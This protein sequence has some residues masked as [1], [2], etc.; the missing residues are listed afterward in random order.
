MSPE[1]IDASIELV[2]RIVGYPLAFVV[3]PFAIATFAGAPGH[4]WAGKTYA[5]AMTFLYLTG[6]A[7]TLTRHPWA[8]WEFARNVTFNLLG[9]SFLLHGWRAMWLRRRPRPFPAWMDQVLVASLVSL[10]GALVWLA[11]ARANTP[12]RVFALVGTALVMLEAMEWRAGL[13]GRVL[14]RRHVRYMLASYFYVLTVVSLV[15]LRD[16][17]SSDAR[18]L[19][20]SAIA[21]AVI[22]VAGG[23]RREPPPR[24]RRWA[25]RAV[26][27]V[28]VAFGAYAGWEVI[29]DDGQV[30]RVLRMVPPPG[31]PRDVVQLETGD[32]VPPAGAQPVA[33]ERTIERQAMAAVAG[34]EAAVDDAVRQR[35]DDREQ[36]RHAAGAGG[37]TVLQL[38]RPAPRDP[39]TSA[40]RRDHR[41]PEPPEH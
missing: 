12:V 23:G 9:Y 40:D 15:H 6:T 8:T 14:H 35:L 10:V 20:P 33:H 38:A 13:T 39:A 16:E 26:L 27:A 3:A 36:V 4:R 31:D 11:F 37:V 30:E 34:G 29:R 22:W 5:V 32:L 24:T 1:R 41:A 18:W 28:S 19:W 25:M 7:L 17:L 21:V 2:H